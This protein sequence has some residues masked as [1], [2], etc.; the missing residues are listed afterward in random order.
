MPVFGVCLTT[1]S[2]KN[3]HCKL[4]QGIVVALTIQSIKTTFMEDVST[5]VLEKIKNI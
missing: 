3:F 4:R 5:E 2:K 1:Q